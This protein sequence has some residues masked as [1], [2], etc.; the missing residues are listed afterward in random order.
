V[1][2]SR[3]IARLER[4]ILET[5]ALAIQREVHD[6]RVGMVTVTRARLA[7]DLSVATVWW[8]CLGDE[9]ERR[10]KSRG[11]AAA[12]HMLQSRV[13]HAMGTRVTPTLSLRFDEGLEKAQRLQG[14]FDRIRA[15]RG[16]PPV[17]PVEGADDAPD[18]GSDEGEPDEDPDAA[19]ARETESGDEPDDPPRADADP[20]APDSE[21]RR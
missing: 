8:S 15:E 11:L 21:T 19:E 6:P 20:A 1:P 7:P 16:E 18:D 17:E 10:T 12:T 13:A 2:T 5:V 14:I 9:G 3:R 4:V